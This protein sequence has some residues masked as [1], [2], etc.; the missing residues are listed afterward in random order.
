MPRHPKVNTAEI[1]VKV[2]VPKGV[3]AAAVRRAL[4]NN[5]HGIIY[6]DWQEEEVLKCST[7][8]P[9]F[10]GGRIVRPAKR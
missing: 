7:I 6:L 2:R 10:S 9:R 8:R 5:W 1:T 4:A 3:S